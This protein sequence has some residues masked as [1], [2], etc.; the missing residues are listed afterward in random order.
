MREI[1][2]AEAIRE[3]LREEMAR[4]ERVFIMGESI[5]YGLF[6]VTA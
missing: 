1:T 6:G 3:A 2:Y 4:D 5:N